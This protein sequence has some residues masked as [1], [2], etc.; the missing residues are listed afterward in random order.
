MVLFTEELQPRPFVLPTLVGLIVAQYLKFVFRN[1]YWTVV[2][3][4]KSAFGS[5]ASFVL[6]WRV[7]LTVDHFCS[8]GDISIPWKCHNSNET[9]KKHNSAAVTLS[10]LLGHDAFVFTVPQSTSLLLMTALGTVW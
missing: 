6:V 8:F 1:I 5:Y 4:L 3:Y 10:F 2:K 7:R 9:T